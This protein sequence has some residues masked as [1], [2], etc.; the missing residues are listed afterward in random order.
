MEGLLDGVVPT[1][2]EVVVATLADVALESASEAFALGDLAHPC[3]EAGFVDVF[4]GAFA[5]T[6]RYEVAS[7]GG[8]VFGAPADSAS[9]DVVETWSGSED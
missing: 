7:W 9:G 8:E 6:R 3:V 2:G 1:G 5:G 4:A